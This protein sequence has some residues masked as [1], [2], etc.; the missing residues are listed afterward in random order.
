MGVR[1]IGLPYPPY[2]VIIGSAETEGDGGVHRLRMVSQTDLR[3]LLQWFQQLAAPLARRGVL[4][5]MQVDD[6]AGPSFI[7]VMID[8]LSP[9]AGDVHDPSEQWLSEAL[10]RYV[11]GRWQFRHVKAYLAR[12]Y[13]YLNMDE[14]DHLTAKV[15]AYVLSSALS[16]S[17]RDDTPSK[18]VSLEGPLVCELREN[19]GAAR[20]EINLD[21]LMRFRFADY[22]R[23]LHEWIDGFV[24]DYLVGKE[25]DEFVGLLRYFLETYPVTPGRVH[26]LI[27][28]EAVRGFD[29]H[30]IP[31]DLTRVEQ[32]AS[33]V[34]DDDLHPQDVL[35]SALITRSPEKLVLHSDHPNQG[36]AKT[37]AEVFAGRVEICKTCPNCDVLMTKV[38][39]GAGGVYTKI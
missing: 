35:I 26:V 34:V 10:A 24:D 1:R 2:T 29:D 4:L 14:I 5:F 8:E 31:L 19:L 12:E 32:I 13:S 38:D 6:P 30:F 15:L 7:D 16:G 3:D 36:F 28:D 17:I 9:G 39:G 21:G 27:T 33:T 37:V 18:A 23:Q 25:Y 22:L 20:R 11:R